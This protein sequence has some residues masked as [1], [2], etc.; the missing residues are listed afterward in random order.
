M[1]P[2]LSFSFLSP[3]LTSMSPT[4][5]SCCPSL[6]YIWLLTSSEHPWNHSSPGTLPTLNGSAHASTRKQPCCCCSS[7]SGR[8]ILQQSTGL[9]WIWKHLCTRGCISHAFTELMN[10]SKFSFRSRCREIEPFAGFVFAAPW[11]WRTAAFLPS[12]SRHVHNIIDLQ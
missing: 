4:R 6:S 3:P 7:P 12:E 5:F 10:Q 9:V 1:C 2:V 11:G 8:L